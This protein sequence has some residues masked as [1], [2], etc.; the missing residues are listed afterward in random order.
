MEFIDIQNK[1]KNVI[2]QSIFHRIFY[3]N[4]ITSKIGEIIGEIQKTSEDI[5]KDV[6]H[7]QQ[8]KEDLSEIKINW[9]SEEKIN[10]QLKNDIK[11]LQ[12]KVDLLSPLEIKNIE[13]ANELNEM[14]AQKNAKD[15]EHRTK[16]A[17]LE[18]WENN[19]NERYQIH[20]EEK[21]RKLNEK[22]EKLKRTWQDHEDNVNKEIK[23]ICQ[24]E[25]ISFIEEWHHEKK[26]DNVIKICNEYIVFDAKSPRN[27][28]LNNFPTYIKSQVSNL[29]KYANHKDV[30]K[31]L[32]L[33]VPNNTIEV[34][35]KQLTY[36]D[37]NYCVHIISPQSLRITMW[38]LKQIELYEFAEK[39]SPEDRENLARVYAGSQNY[40]KRIV[41]IN[42][43]V[44]EMGLDLIAQNMQ[45]ISK[46]SL[47]GIQDNA[48]EMEQMDIINVSKQNR[49]KT[50][51]AKEELRRQEHIRF[52]AQ[53]QSIISTPNQNKSKASN[54][55]QDKT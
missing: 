29:S 7:Y 43:D 35:Q 12:N 5:K 50:I 23:L 18:Q 47:K 41:Q 27:E 1:L 38:S 22:I 46:E 16:M 30:K 21:E 36:N 31:H 42:N 34:L 54:I 3:W 20:K 45:L 26:P 48:L 10:T 37:S 52:K 8:L 55:K 6:D 24:D 9:K 40:I 15:T 25:A 14:K 44:N 51:D 17:R 4:S 19:Q 32:F 53:Q 39:L 13:L 28:E 33:V 49:G 11:I 2:N